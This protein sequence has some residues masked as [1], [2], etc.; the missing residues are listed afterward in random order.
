[1]LHYFNPGHE[2]AV[3]NGSPYYH[4]P[5]NV[6]QM[7]CDLAFLPA[8]YAE[9]GDWVLTKSLLPEDFRDCWL[10]LRN[11]SVQEIADAS[12]DFSELFKQ[13]VT[14]WGISPQSIHQMELFSEKHDLHLQIPSWNTL[15]YTF[16]HRQKSA[17]YL[18][19]LCDDFS[20][21]SNK[22]SSCFCTS[23]DEID[24]ILAKES[25]VSFLAKAP[26]SS[27]GRGLLWLPKE[28]LTRTEQQI[29]IGHLKKQGGVFIERVL[30]KKQDFAME[31]CCDGTGKCRFEGFSLFETNDKGG[32]SGNRMLSQAQIIEILCEKIPLEQIEAVKEKL[33]GLFSAELASLYKGYVGVDMMIYGENEEFK[34]QPC[35]EINL[36]ANMGVLAI[37]LQQKYI[38][39]ETIGHFFVEYDK[40]AFE[41]HTALK[42]QYPA[43]FEDG[44]MRSGYFSLC[45]VNQETKYLAYLLLE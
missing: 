34:L 17:D 18:N 27:S 37:S 21:V 41:K 25:N 38:Q 33:Q 42:I 36:R 2:V 15:F 11:F 6:L 22:L 10:S 43:K 26:Y 35:V 20:F 45:P 7:Q 3:L 23:L 40:N 4:P 19:L 32:Y 12:A 30:S 5:A 1:M 44:K 16:T 29:L 13:E 8:W 14:L 9:K 24:A 28:K 39:P 31:F